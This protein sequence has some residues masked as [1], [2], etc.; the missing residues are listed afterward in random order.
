MIKKVLAIFVSI[1]VTCSQGY[2][3][4]PVASNIYPKR[5]ILGLSEISTS[6][7]D[8]SQQHIKPAP[9]IS[10][11]ISTSQWKTALAELGGPIVDISME[12]ILPELGHDAIAGSRGG[13]GILE[14]DSGEGYAKAIS[15]SGVS[16]IKPFIIMPWYEYKLVPVTD[17][18][19]RRQVLHRQKVNYDTLIDHSSTVDYTIFA[20]PGGFDYPAFK[21]NLSRPIK[22]VTGVDGRQLMFDVIMYDPPSDSYKNF[23]AA[24]FVTNRGGTPV[25]MIACQDVADILYTDSEEGRLSQQ[26]LVGKV[27]PMLL[28]ALGIKPAILRLNEAHTVIAMAGMMDDPYFSD[29]AYIF[30]NHTPITAGL[31]IY[32]SRGDWFSR[33]SLPLHLREIFVDEDNNLDFSRAAMILAHIVNTVSGAHKDTLTDMFPDFRHKI[34]GVLNGTGELW[35]SSLLRKAEQRLGQ[36]TPARLL[37]IHESDKDIFINLIEQRTGA[38][39]DRDMPIAAAI[40]RIDYYK[41][42]LPML[43]PI[44]KA[45]CQ[46]KGVMT[47]INIDGM[48][49]EVEGLGMQVVVGGII[50]DKHNHDLQGWIAEFISWMLDPAFKGRFVFISGNDTELMKAAASGPDCWFEVPRRNSRTGHQ[51]EASG[52]SGMRAA[53]NGNIPIMSSGMWGDEFVEEYN[54]ETGRGNGFILNDITPLELY[55]ALSDISRLYYGYR[56]K[57]DN[58]WIE[59]RKR[60]YEDAKSLYIKNMIMRYVL[61]VFLP[62]INAKK[63]E[64]AVRRSARLLPLEGGADYI[65]A[66][67]HLEVAADIITDSPHLIKSIKAQVWTDINSKGSWYEAGMSSKVREKDGRLIVRFSV[68]IPLNTIGE[69][70]Y[71]VRFVINDNGKII[72]VPEGIGNDLSIIVASPVVLSRSRSEKLSKGQSLRNA[73]TSSA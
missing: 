49:M 46:D 38:R 68:K 1:M 48:D 70:S 20:K 17:I 3:L 43:R 72:Y 40:R 16:G 61:E 71:K 28:K 39:L 21:H 64:D 23:N 5:D 53:I 59:L 32:Y 2:C 8:T 62:A 50:V 58:T 29:T 56:D 35:K 4:R 51:E 55:Q 25:F 19:G 24:I 26:V 7:S 67:N 57:Q 66:G 45:L 12:A 36:L 60:V 44:V 34:K 47:H 42:Q 9:Y 69:F 73:V 11:V 41:Q 22:R 6:A 54:A 18:P 63:A 14:G 10:P 65:I 37:E 33:L 30:T 27:V 52:T 15:D 13:L 31:Q